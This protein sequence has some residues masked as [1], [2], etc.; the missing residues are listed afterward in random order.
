MS[1]LDRNLEK[2]ESKTQ[3]I[4]HSFFLD[5]AC[6]PLTS[7]II[8]P[9][10]PAG[11]MKPQPAIFAGRNIVSGEELSFDYA[12]ASGTLWAEENSKTREGELGHRALTKC[13]C[14]SS[15]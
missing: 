13:L 6:P 10:R 1:A 14:G 11:H 3:T 8:L 2:T 15:R 5:H 7:L 9:V 4:K 12:D